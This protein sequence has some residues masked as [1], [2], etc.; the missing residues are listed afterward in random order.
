MH[1]YSLQKVAHA[2]TEPGF[3]YRLQ[4]CSLPQP[5]QSGSSHVYWLHQGRQPPRPDGTEPVAMCVHSRAAG[6]MCDDVSL[7][8][9]RGLCRVERRGLFDVCM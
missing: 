8:A 7:C 6:G 5:L 2:F 1:V 3:T 4:P 9:A